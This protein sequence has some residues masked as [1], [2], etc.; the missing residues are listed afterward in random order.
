MSSLA[1]LLVRPRIAMLACRRRNFFFFLLL[2]HFPARHSRNL[3][4]FNHTQSNLSSSQ[5]ACDICIYS[6]GRGIQ[7]P[8]S[9]FPFPAFSYHETALAVGISSCAYQQGPL[10][11][12]TPSLLRTRSP[13]STLLTGSHSKRPLQGQKQPG[14]GVF[15]ESITTRQLATKVHVCINQIKHRR[16]LLYNAAL[17]RTP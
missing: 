4:L 13:T 12:S 14:L 15:K 2:R 10:S 11:K 1:A 16:Q 7:Q 17:T 3:A 8:I 9:K 6:A 5:Q